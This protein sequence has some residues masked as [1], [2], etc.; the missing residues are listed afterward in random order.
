MA[1]TTSTTQQA[2]TYV[3]PSETATR[4]LIS[5]NTPTQVVST[6]SHDHEAAGD[7]PV[8]LRKHTD[9]YEQAAAAAAREGKAEGMG[10]ISGTDRP[11][12][13]RQASWDI[14]DKR[15]DH[16]EAY[17]SGQP[18]GMGYSSGGK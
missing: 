15:R 16:H 4:S 14:R 12:F 3:K 8:M 2:F 11:G 13:Q 18:A 9:N 17:L 6:S 1:S 5:G 7:R 10:A